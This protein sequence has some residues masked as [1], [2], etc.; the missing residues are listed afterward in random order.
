MSLLDIISI[1]TTRHFFCIAFVFLSGKVEKDYMWAF[2]RLKTLYEQYGGIFLSVILTD[3]CLTII[4]IALVL[5]LSA[6]AL[7]I[8]YANKVVLA[9][10]QPAFNT[11][12]EW[13]N[14][15]SY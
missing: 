7:C 12:E 5:F 9:E 15:Y 3:H 13:K 8:W 6:T 10:Y 11:A 1:D 4:N 2:T 14:F